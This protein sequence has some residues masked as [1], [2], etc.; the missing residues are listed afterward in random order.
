MSLMPRL[1]TWRFPMLLAI[2]SLALTGATA[3]GGTVVRFVTNLGEFDVDLYD[4]TMPTTVANFLAYVTTDR[5]A[6]TI[7]HR[8]TTYNP[9]DIQI[10]QGGG[11]LFDNNLL[12]PVEADPPIPLEPSSANLRGTLAMAR[13]S[14]PNSATSQWYFNVTD[15]P[16]LDFSYAVFGDVIGTGLDVIDAIGAVPVYNAS[17]DLGPT[18]SQLPLLQPSLEP[19]SLVLVN[20]VSVVQPWEVTI[21]V[22]SGTQTQEQAGYPTIATAASVTKTGLG[23][24]VYNAANT[25]QGPTTVTAGTLEIAHPDAVAGSSV[26][27]DTGAT[28]QVA[29]GTILRSP[30]VV[31][32]GGVLSAATLSVNATTGITS[33]EINAGSLAGSPLVAIGSGGEMVLAEDARVIVGV[34]G[35][36]VE[37]TGTGGRVDLGSGEVTVAAGGI[38]AADLRASI[39]AGRSGGAWD[40]TTGIMSSAAAA[41]DG[42]RAVGYLV[43][44]DGSMRVSFAAAGDVDLSGQVNVFDLVGINSASKYGTGTPADWSQGDFNYDGVTNVFDLVGINSAV[45]Y[46]QGNYFPTSPTA[47]G[48]VAAV[49]EPSV[50]LLGLAGLATIAVAGLRRT[51]FTDC[52]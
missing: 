49:P 20:S 46:G 16:G 47:V 6:S 4:A 19:Q 41:S 50:W 31:V 3:R 10:V 24:L 11:F 48:S 23:T 26:T 45:V 32:D 27:I 28:L 51:F 39:I 13:T 40:G 7:F 1:A 38:S 12:L 37:A 18:F 17:T 52:S 35:L 14:D 15:N 34:G 29:S 43:A 44:N 21:N 9:N 2:V 25:Y 5:Y 42:K 33:L 8:S 30:A 22:P 36:S